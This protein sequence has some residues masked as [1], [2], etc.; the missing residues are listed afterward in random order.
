MKNDLFEIIIDD[1]SYSSDEF[2]ALCKYHDVVP[3]IYSDGMLDSLVALWNTIMPISK[4]AT[5]LFDGEA[6]KGFK[7]KISFNTVEDCNANGYVADPRNSK[8]KY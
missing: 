3:S 7:R 8:G 1:Q 5:L 2:R 4:S 6:S